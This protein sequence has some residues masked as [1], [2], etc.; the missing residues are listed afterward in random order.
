MVKDR[1]ELVRLFLKA[2]FE[3]ADELNPRTLKRLILA[4]YDGKNYQTAPMLP[5]FWNGKTQVF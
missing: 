2:G 5:I 4:A 3:P 1:S